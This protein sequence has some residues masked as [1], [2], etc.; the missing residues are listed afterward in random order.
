MPFVKEKEEFIESDECITVDDQNEDFI[1]P[2]ESNTVD[3]QN[4][5][6]RESDEDN[7]VDDQ[8][9]DILAMKNSSSVAEGKKSIKCP[10]CNDVF[11]TID[12]MKS[13]IGSAHFQLW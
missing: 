9:E 6:F 10:V 1:E 7:T 4:E 13:H 3:D 8:N 2:D 11:F 12:Q 5:D